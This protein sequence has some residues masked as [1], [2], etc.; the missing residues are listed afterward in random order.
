[1]KLKLFTFLISL[2]C[3]STSTLA[4]TGIQLKSKDGAFINGRTVEFATKIQLNILVIPKNYEFRGT[5]PDGSASGLVYKSKYAAIGGYMENQEVLVDGLNE[6]GLSVGAFYFP[7]YAQ[8]PEINQKN[9]SY[10]LSPLEFPNWLLTQFATVEE[11]KAALK[12]QKIVIAPTLFKA[13]NLVPPFHYVV[14]DKTG[15]SIAIEPLNG[16]LI[17]YEN[18]LG[19]MTNSPEFSWHM[20]NLRNYLNLSPDNVSQ[21]TLKEL[22]L[23]PFGEG[24]GMRGIPGDFTPP[25][26]FVRATFFSSAAVTSDTAK[27]TVFQMFHLLNQFDIPLGSV[28]SSS[29]GTTHMDYTMFTTVKDPKNLIYYIKT[30]EN[31]NVEMVSLNSFDLNGKSLKRIYLKKQ[32]LIEDL[33]KNVDH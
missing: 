23:K 28:R 6:A 32:Q 3:F 17:V 31:Q 11:V 18:P 30:Y 13:W 12:D 25:S 20:A 1:M 27:D 21:T 29:N 26:R 14:Y 10:A 4:C 15:K 9:Q 19:V 5:L 2:L 8:Y 33:G 16:K 7:G 24:S 22:T